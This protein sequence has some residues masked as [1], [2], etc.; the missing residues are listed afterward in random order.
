[1]LENFIDNCLVPTH[2]TA[3]E[4]Q[5]KVSKQSRQLRKEVFLLSP[6]P[7]KKIVHKL[8]ASVTFFLLNKHESEVVHLFAQLKNFMVAM[9]LNL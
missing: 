9:L 8:R 2:K 1:M 5:K 7:R 6:I 4:P 3:L